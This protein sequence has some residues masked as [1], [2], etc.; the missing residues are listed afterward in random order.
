MGTKPPKELYQDFEKL[1]EK[2]DLDLII[3]AAKPYITSVGRKAGT[4]ANV[5]YNI[6]PSIYSHL[7]QWEKEFKNL[8]KKRINEIQNEK[9]E[10]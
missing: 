10:K 1:R 4:P 6:L 5:Y 7:V 8:V 9:G 2:Y 3:I